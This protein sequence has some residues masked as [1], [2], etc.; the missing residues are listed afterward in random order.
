MS[1]ENVEIICRMHDAFNEEGIESVAAAFLGENVEF[2]EPPE[3]PGAKVA[4]GREETIEY[5]SGFDE[6]WESHV[7]EVE[8][9]RALDADRVLALSVEHFRGRNGIEVTQPCGTI[10]TLDRG[11]VIRW[12]AFWNRDTALELARR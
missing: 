11:K 1:Q 4:R 5:F 2:R 10:Y 6:A 9:V 8:E 7:S 3:Q 12:E